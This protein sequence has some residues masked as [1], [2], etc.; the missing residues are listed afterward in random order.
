M[1]VDMTDDSDRSALDE[2]VDI[3]TDRLGVL[4]EQLT[5]GVQLSRARID[6]LTDGEMVW[7][8]VPGSWSVR[9]RSEATSPDAYGPGD[10]VLDHDS[11]LD[12]F[13][14]ATVSTIAWRVGH[15]VSMFAGRWEWTFGGR[16]TDPAAL[17]DFVPEAS[18]AD[19][20]WQEIDRWATSLE[21]LTDEQLD[22][23]G[24]GQYPWG[25][26]PHIAFVGIVRWINREAIHHLAEIALLRDLYAARV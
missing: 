18:M 14:N 3:R 13:A 12:P 17:V 2:T 20:L 21:G 4:V 22:E 10:Y 26:D 11:S 6:G 16:T 25:I 15:L 19:R 24:F 9:L 23:V 7:E 1:I 8:P 5:D